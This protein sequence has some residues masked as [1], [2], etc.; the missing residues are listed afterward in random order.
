MKLIGKKSL[1]KNRSIIKQ[2]F[3]SKKESKIKL[4]IA[5]KKGKITIEEL[6]RSLKFESIPLFIIKDK[7]P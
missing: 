6:R 2:V 4:L 1:K 5:L 7:K 3:T